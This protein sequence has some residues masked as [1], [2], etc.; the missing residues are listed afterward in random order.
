MFFAGKASEIRFSKEAA[1]LL[2]QYA[3]PGNVRELKNLVERLAI[4]KP[5]KVIAPVDLPA[6]FHA[7]G[8]L[9]AQPDEATLN[10]RMAKQ[11]VLQEFHRGFVESALKKHGG[12]V[13]KASESLGLDRGNFQRILRRYGLQ[14]SDYRDEG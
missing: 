11:K 4:L 10:Y 14:A 5:G 2:F 7:Q 1:S 3:W 9:A 6:E 13:S 8:A 12:N